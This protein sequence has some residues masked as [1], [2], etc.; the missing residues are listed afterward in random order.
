MN[1][2]NQPL[3]FPFTQPIPIGAQSPYFLRAAMPVNY[4]P[5]RLQ[6]VIN[7]IQRMTQAPLDLVAVC[8]L[9]VMSLSCQD[10][11][12]VSPKEKLR[13]AT[14][15][16][17]MIL[18]ESGER[19]STID[20]IIMSPIREFER[21][22][23]AQYKEDKKKY[24]SE[25]YMWSIE[26]KALEKDYARAI[27][28]GT[29]KEGCAKSLAACK[30]REPNQ[31]VRSRLIVNDA[32]RAAIKQELGMGWPSLFLYS[33]E[34]GS[35]LKGEMLHD[36]P[37]M[38]SLWSGKPIEVDRAGSMGF[39]IE[40]ER[41][42]YM[43]QVQ[44]GL[45]EEYVKQ[46]GQRARASGLFART[47][48]CKPL[49]TIGFRLNS[50]L[51]PQNATAN[52]LIWFQARVKELLNRSF[53]RRKNQTDRVC[54]TLSVEAAAN[55]HQEYQR[56]EQMCGPMGNL[57]DFR[58]YASK[59]LEHVARIAGVLEAFMTGGPVISESSMVAAINFG[60]YFL[61]SFITLNCEN[62]LPEELEDALVLE[63]WLRENHFKANYGSISKNIILKYGPSRIRKRERLNRALD[64]L[65]FKGVVSITKIKRTTYVNYNGFNFPLNCSWR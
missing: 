60:N 38:N 20:S 27:A 3:S 7:E 17:L 9:G 21:E 25:K 34:A 58:D 15:L 2:Y 57:K 6:E 33:D 62:S 41:F 11:F 19:K 61:N 49:S 36:T 13:F 1:P 29:E 47:L 46:H 50:S 63:N 37:L 18:A 35:I 48:L 56:I 45:Y 39:R 42:G 59:Q 23:E 28:K 8:C 40:D 14:S 51:E 30:A 24:D 53:D 5:A 55:W 16:Y 32:T 22:L 26:L 65:S 64:S 31:P 10:L 44:P 12:D 43:L 52:E 54:L 4:L